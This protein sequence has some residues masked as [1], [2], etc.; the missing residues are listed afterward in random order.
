MISRRGALRGLCAVI[1]AASTAPRA[2]ARPAT[3]FV[4][5]PSSVAHD[6]G[7]G[8]PDR[9]ERMHAFLDALSK[10]RFQSLLRLEA[11]ASSTEAILRVHTPALVNRL[12]V[13]APKDG[14]AR[15]SA[16]SVMNPAT[17][18][19]ALSS[20]GGALRAV[21]AVMRGE[22]KNAFVATRPPGHH[23][24]AD[25]FMGFCF[26]NNAAIATRHALAA[27]GAE[28]VAIVD[29]DVHHGN[30]VQEIF[31]SDKNVLYCSTHQSPLYPGSG[32]ANE[33]GEFGNIV[34]A[35]LRKGDGGEQFRMAL[36]EAVLPRVESF[37]P[38]VVIL[39]A[40]FDAH[41]HDPLGGLRLV[42]E[43]FR[44]ATLR[45]M[46]I[47]ARRCGSRIVSLL[48]GG[49]NPPDLA[50]SVAAHVGALLEA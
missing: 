34:N 23:A 9:P 44:D 10:P 13:S 37:R 11:A 6:M 40:G 19:A 1:G 14:Y 42:E 30:G 7:P 46:E 16:D 20:A 45:I 24:T 35:P 31:W 5:H 26:L 50:A 41:I 22:T 25:S 17:R 32:A 49:Y 18:E 33:R 43:D 36:N 4:S 38:D 47:A 29:F 12:T 2:A 3:V 28:R 39:C 27:H 21:D 15:L 8:Y 48:E